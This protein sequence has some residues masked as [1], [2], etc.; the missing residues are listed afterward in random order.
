MQESVPC[1]RCPLADQVEQCQQSQSTKLESAASTEI[2]SI[3]KKCSDLSNDRDFKQGHLAFVP[4]AV[5]S[6]VDSHEPSDTHV[7]RSAAWLHI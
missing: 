3:S 2:T 5:Y 4:K 6:C 7:R 1:R